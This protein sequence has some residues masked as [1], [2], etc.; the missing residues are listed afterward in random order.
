MK[1]E[2][3][4]KEAIYP[5]LTIV[6]LIVLIIFIL[7]QILVTLPKAD[8]AAS[9]NVDRIERFRSE[10]DFK[11]YL[12]RTG[13]SSSTFSQ[14]Y[15]FRSSMTEELM[16]TE[17]DTALPER[18]SETNVQVKGI[19]E[20]DIFKTDGR[21]FY[22]SSP[23]EVFNPLRGT[24]RVL[25]GSPSP[26]PPEP[27]AGVSSIKAFPPEQLAVAAD[28]KE[29]GDLLLADRTLV[30]F[31]GNKIQGYDVSNPQEPNLKWTIKVSDNNQRVGARLLDGKIYLVQRNGL[32]IDRPCPLEILSGPKGSL[33]INCTEIY[34]PVSQTP[35]DVVF[36]ALVLDPATGAT[37]KSV[38]FV[39]SSS[40]SSIY[41][42]RQ[43]LYTTYYRPGD[44]IGFLYRFL[45]ENSDL[46]P[47]TFIDRLGRLRDYDLSLPAKMAEL[48]EIA[49][50][51]FGGLDPDDRL[52]QQNELENRLS[53]YNQIHKRE[54][55]STGIVKISLND[56]SIKASGAVPGQLLNQFSLDEYQN[57]LRV[58]TTVGSP[59]WLGGFGE[60]ISGE[61]ANDLYILNQNLNQLGRV[62]DLGLT[63]RIFSARF[64]E[65]K[66]YLVT[67][68]QTD[69]FYV[70][71][72][73]SPKQPKL[74]GQLKIPGF[75]SYLDPL[76]KNLILGVGQAD[77]EVKLSL[78]D[79][80]D[81]QNPIEKDK[82][83]LNDYWSEVQSNHHAF[84]VDQ[85]FKIFFLP[86]GRGGYVLS[87]DNDKL[88]LVK[89]ISNISARRAAYINDYLYI[90]GD[91]RI[92]VLRENDWSTVNELEL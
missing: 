70:L 82:Y 32:K 20:P 29:S 67:F 39:G 35:V 21:Q 58:A 47:N 6:G 45:R 79:V 28:I 80:R 51:Y 41:M 27:V 90:V 77:G 86:G 63:E 22:F 72:L 11:N 1:R 25:P 75:S 17:A 12:S 85:K 38:S 50:Q 76:T 23:R 53:R 46:F 42:S 91:D 68:R 54:V 33:T 13:S 36:T 16:H 43:H 69:P 19:D 92:V 55:D 62:V 64:V 78:F 40:V 83:L 37:E 48:S 84:Q 31:S 73:S 74:A 10:E 24:E 88:K 3:P 2:G 59:I 66:A 34:H 30:I 56:F 60:P 49:N 5:I 57:N 81:P 7:K 8:E 89:A 18:F 61:T 4:K 87:F 71:D 65:D 14:G 52:K 9:L 26:L 15:G 44:L